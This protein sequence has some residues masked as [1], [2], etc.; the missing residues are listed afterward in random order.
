MVPIATAHPPVAIWRVVVLNAGDFG[1]SVDIERP[2]TLAGS[3]GPVIPFSAVLFLGGSILVSH[4]VPTIRGLIKLGFFMRISRC[5]ET[6]SIS[7]WLRAS[8]L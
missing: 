4:R 5:D 2:L 8:E 7:P 3:S 1:K 6:G